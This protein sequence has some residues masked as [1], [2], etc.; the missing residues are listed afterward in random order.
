MSHVRS[1]RTRSQWFTLLAL[2]ALAAGACGGISLE[3]APSPPNVA[4]AAGV[5]PNDAASDAGVAEPGAGGA[6]QIGPPASRGGG[7]NAANPGAPST[8]P[9]S[10][11]SMPSPR[12]V[13]SSGCSATRTDPEW[14]GILICTGNSIAHRVQ[15]VACPESAGSGSSP[16]GASGMSNGDA[17][18]GEG[19]AGSMGCSIDADCPANSLCV[20]GFGGN[21]CVPANCRTDADCGAGSWCA[22]VQLACTSSTPVFAWPRSA[23]GASGFACQSQADECDDRADC[24]QYSNSNHHWLCAWDGTLR[25]CVNEELSSCF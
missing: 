11:T 14:P 10:P 22:E 21:T 1:R 12:H 13:S 15:A 5:A 23:Y 7:S 16:A 20:C 17:A 19:G 9:S 3:S 2:T 18:G 25:Q 6:I 24:P 8:P 4:P